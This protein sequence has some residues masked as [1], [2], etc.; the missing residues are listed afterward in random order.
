LDSD[1]ISIGA[2][3]WANKAWDEMS[4][5]KGTS[6]SVEPQIQSYYSDGR[7]QGISIERFKSKYQSDYG[8]WQFIKN[9]TYY[10][11]WQFWSLSPIQRP[12]GS[13]QGKIVPTE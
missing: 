7:C 10:I 13:G 6:L 8:L 3:D 4:Y 9:E 2:G 11:D 12:A 5:F 1:S